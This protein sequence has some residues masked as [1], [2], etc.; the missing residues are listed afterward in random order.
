MQAI[1][2]NYTAYHVHTELSLLDSCTNFQ[3]Y[4]DRAV[5]LGQKAIAFTE[6]GNI[7]QWV[8]KKMYCDKMGIKYLHGVE[9]YLTEALSHRDRATG[10]EFKVRDNYHTILIARNYPGVLELNRLVSLSNSESHSYY[11]PRLSFDEFLGIS[12]NIIKISACLA[13]PLNKL[14]VSHKRYAQLARH[15]D[16]FEIQPHSFPE[17]K[18]FNLHLAQIAKQYGKP[19]IAGT[20]THSI[21]QY[22]AECR[23]VLLA[24]KH[25]EYSDEDSFDLTY[26]SYDELVELFAKQDTLPEA[27]YLEAIENTNRMADSV[28]SFELDLSFKYP[29]LYGAKDKE[30][31]SARIK[32]GLDEKI[33]SGAIRPEQIPGFQK[34]IPEECRVFDKIDMSGFMLF[35][36]E[37]ITWCK[38]NGIPVGFN[39]GSAGGSRVAYVTDITDLNPE[40]WHTVFFRF[41]NEDRKE[42]GDIDIDVS[43]SDRDKVYEYIINRFGQDKTAFILAVGTVKDKGCIDEICRALGVRWDKKHQ[44]NTGVL[45]NVLKALKD[46]SAEVVFDSNASQYLW[47]EEKNSL[48]LPDNMRGISQADL[49]RSLSKEYERIKAENA[50]ISLKNPWTGNINVT[51]KQAFESDPEKARKDYPEVFYFYDGL[52]GTAISQSMHPAGIVASPI[53][54]ADHYGTFID[55]DGHVLLQIDMEC[56]HEVSLVKYDILGLKNIEIVKDAYR[57]IGK[58]Y[59]KSH[60]IDWYDEAVWKDMLRSPVGIFQFEKDFAFSMLRQYEPHSI[61]DM[62]IVTAAIRPSGASYRDALIRHE[63]HHNPSPIIDELLKDNNGYLIYQEDVIKFLQEICG[64]SGSDADNT[65]RAI[66]RKDEARLAEALPQIM[67]GYCSK[68]LQPR[69]VAEGEAREFL[70]IIQDA[71]SYMFNYN[72]SIGYCMLGYLCAYLRCYHP[73]EFITAYLNNANGEEDIQNG[74]ALAE[75]YGI[76]IVPPRFGLSKDKYIFDGEKR[77]IAKGISSIKYLNSAVAN[78]LYD[79][80][81]E[82]GSHSFMELLTLIDERTSLDTRQRDILVRIDY[83]KDYGNIPELSRMVRIFTFFKNGTAKRIAKSKLDG[84]MLELVSQFASDKN[85]DGSEAKSFTITDM[86]GLLLACES[87]VKSFHLPDLDLKSKIQT[88]LELMGYIDLTTKRPEDRRKLLIT[89]V[90]PLIS[91]ENGDTWG[92]ALQTRSV[93]SGKTARLTVRSDT[94]KRNPIKKFDIVIAKDLKKKKSGYWYL[95]DYERIA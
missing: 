29:K 87:A 60:E 18:Q 14:P 39:R 11:K 36:S 24:A 63:P 76:Q 59:P 13:S 35:M 80:S 81:K 50:A 53:T 46:Q 32:A 78:E 43:P 16:Y 21:N 3:L 52:L 74:S 31:F 58:P 84:Q 33:A 82:I 72:H 38:S 17:Q 37:L 66:G 61:F 27:L 6:H 54:L 56:V 86:H 92:H 47:D 88:Q 25:I 42:I 28:E 94:Y 7:Y 55:S 79:L 45:K 95:L 49:I 85:K 77:V 8:A 5:E 20:D 71:S 23:S 68:S 41:C 30:I 69:S 19:L 2:R 4:V 75:T 73:F 15:Y 9:C 90:Y 44:L 64:F 40:E 93:G 57:I 1:N 65:R 48:L 67:E 89:D 70:Q 91:K 12:N 62:S 10:E 51:I 34:A 26:K 22:K 83:F